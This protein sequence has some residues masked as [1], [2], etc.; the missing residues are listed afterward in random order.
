MIPSPTSSTFSRPRGPLAAFAFPKFRRVWL[1]SVIF[2]LGN[3]GE[4]LAT[5]WVVLNETD[6][7]FLAAATFAVRQAPQLIFA[8]IGGAVAD[9]FSRGKIVLLI[10]IYKALILT[11]LA[12]IAANGLEP[13]WLVFVILGFSGV[14]QSFELPA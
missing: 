5:G 14:G 12:I 4:R 10:S 13:L 8:P 6:D 2:S 3:W 1:A 11:A 9:R 7:V